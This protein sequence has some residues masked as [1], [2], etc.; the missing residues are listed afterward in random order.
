MD[1]YVRGNEILKWII[2]NE[3]LLGQ[4]QFE[5]DSYVILDDDEDMLYQQRHNFIRVNYKTGLTRR[6]VHKA[7][8]I[9]SN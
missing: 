3:E 8:K 5:F 9:L 2:D 4:H 7:C 1:G 6:D